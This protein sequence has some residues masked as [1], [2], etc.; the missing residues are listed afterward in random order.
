MG[1]FF[2]RGRIELFR[3]YSLKCNELFNFHEMKWPLEEKKMRLILVKY[4][5]H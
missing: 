2:F 3:K 4:T 5:N 1:I